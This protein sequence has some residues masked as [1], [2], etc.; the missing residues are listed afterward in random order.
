MRRKDD[1]I[2]FEKCKITTF[3][4]NKFRGEYFPSRLTL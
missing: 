3:N 4:L 2:K 1:I